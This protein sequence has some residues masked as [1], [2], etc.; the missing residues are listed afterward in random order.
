MTTLG[1]A[2]LLLGATLVVVEA[3]VPGGVFGVAGGIALMAGGVI[4][5]GALGGGLALALP[6]ALGIGCVVAAWTLLVVRKTAGVRRL[7]AR[8][9]AEGLQGQVGVV[10]AWSDPAGQ[11]FVDG[12]LWR[13]RSEWDE[14]GAAALHAGDPVVVERVRGL[15]LSVR[16]AEEW[17]LL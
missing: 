9:G 17:E 3:H 2:L 12:A 16:R 11:V 4:A 1:F 5:V 8:S 15:T 6:V 7:R 13:A 14:P 10:R